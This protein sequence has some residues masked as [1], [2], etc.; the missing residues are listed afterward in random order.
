MLPS[1]LCHS[2]EGKKTNDGGKKTPQDGGGGPIAQISTRPT[3]AGN[4]K[5]KIK[6]KERNGAQVVHKRAICTKR[7][8]REKGEKGGRG[9]SAAHPG[10]MEVSSANS[11]SLGRQ[12]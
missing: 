6:R 11:K 2:A 4:N 1:S 9:E 3:V 12:S 10:Q 8:F 7:N 5:L